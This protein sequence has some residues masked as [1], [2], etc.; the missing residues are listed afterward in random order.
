MSRNI[1]ETLEWKGPYTSTRSI[2]DN[3]G[4]YMALSGKTDEKGKWSTNLYKLLD[5]GQAGRI[6]SRLDEHERRDC[7]AR[8][9]PS[10]SRLSVLNHGS[11][12]GP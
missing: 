6:K 1:E 2:S 8:A 11:K 12:N 3:A 9:A 7:C 4:I 5:I 10:S